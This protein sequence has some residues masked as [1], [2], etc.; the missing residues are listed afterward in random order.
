[1][2]NSFGLAR[3]EYGDFLILMRVII[4]RIEVTVLLFYALDFTSII[5]RCP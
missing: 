1:V 5:A 3:I 2:G 4:S